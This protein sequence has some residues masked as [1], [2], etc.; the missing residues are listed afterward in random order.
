MHVLSNQPGIQ[1]Y[2]GNF[3]DAT[4]V[5]K[6]GKLYRQGD[7][8]VLEP[9]MFPDATVWSTYG[10]GYLFIPLVLPVVGGTAA[11]DLSGRPFTAID[12]PVPDLYVSSFLTHA[13][14]LS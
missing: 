14:A 8:I 9:Q 7:A 12:V 2:S 3:L 11:L 4:I 10:R 13:T 5:G 6:S 1:F